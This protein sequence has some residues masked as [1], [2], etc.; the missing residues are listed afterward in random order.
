MISNKEIWTIDNKK[1]HQNFINLTLDYSLFNIFHIQFTEVKKNLTSDKVAF[2]N[3]IYS[4]QYY[5]FNGLP[6]NMENDDD[7]REKIIK[8]EYDIIEHYK[9][10]YFNN[11]TPCYELQN[12]I[13]KKSKSTTIL[14]KISGIWENRNQVGIMWKID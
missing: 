8:I 2:S 5:S 11:K 12:Y 10:Y 13:S 4:T 6:L 9:S 7:I 1:N 3:I 14:L